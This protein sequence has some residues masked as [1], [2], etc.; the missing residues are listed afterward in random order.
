MVIMCPMGMEHR[1]ALKLLPVFIA[2]LSSPKSST[3]CSSQIVPSV[4]LLLMHFLTIVS[5]L[6][7]L[8]L[9]VFLLRARSFRFRN[10]LVYLI[11]FLGRFYASN[12]ESAIQNFELGIPAPCKMSKES[13]LPQPG[14][15]GAEIPEQRHSF[16]GQ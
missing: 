9:G 6:V 4:T 16:S 1:L 13:E 8:N 15:H 7:P 14:P 5:C 2:F 11:L 3:L 12:F 10:L